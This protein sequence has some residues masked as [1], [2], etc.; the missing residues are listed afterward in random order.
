VAGDY[1]ILDEPRPG[2]LARL[3]VNPLWPLL[4]VMFGGTWISWPWFV[5]NAFAVGS[6]TRWRETALAAAGFAGT[7]ALF[8]GLV[9][10]DARGVFGASGL[11]YAGVG[12]VVWKLAVSYWLYV[13]QGRTFALFEYFHGA[14]RNGVL[15]VFAGY[16]LSRRLFDLLADAPFGGL[17]QVV[18]R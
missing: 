12:L 1:R 13:L 6:P 7:A 5:V 14:A 17:L 4:A 2:A 10:L 18:L 16:F 8:V 11:A 15:V 9:L 3:A